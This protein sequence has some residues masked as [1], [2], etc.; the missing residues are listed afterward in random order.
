MSIPRTGLSLRHGTFSGLPRRMLSQV[1]LFSSSPHG[2]GLSRS[3]HG[4]VLTFAT[5]GT[6]F[7]GA[8]TGLFPYSPHGRVLSQ[9]TH[10]SVLTFST[11]GTAFPRAHTALFSR[12]PHEARPSSGHTRPR[13]SGPP[14][15]GHSFSGRTQDPVLPTRT[16]A[17]RHDVL[18]IKKRARAGSFSCALSFFLSFSLLRSV[19]PEL[20]CPP[21]RKRR[22]RAL[23][24]PVQLFT[25]ICL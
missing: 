8:R 18:P 15:R 7:P 3:T 2:R 23:F 19:L 14:H 20:R 13:S 16:R 17:A 11:R 22:C 6:A 1:S 12:S 5:R 25:Y 4:S 10:G 9:S 21:D 24:C